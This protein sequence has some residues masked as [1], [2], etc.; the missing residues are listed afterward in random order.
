MVD[1]TATGI[2]ADPAPAKA[3]AIRCYEKAG[4]RQVSLITTPDGD[5]LLMVID[6]P[7][8]SIPGRSFL[9]VL[10]DREFMEPDLTLRIDQPALFCWRSSQ[11]DPALLPV[12]TLKNVFVPV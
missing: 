9:T 2:Q 12:G 7:S 8:Y 4:F 11:Q 3:Q 6:R 5:A 1:P 10:A